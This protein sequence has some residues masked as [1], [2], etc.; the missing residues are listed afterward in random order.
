MALGLFIRAY[1]EAFLLI[2]YQVQ[3][4]PLHRVPLSAIYQASYGLREGGGILIRT[5]DGQKK[6]PF[7]MFSATY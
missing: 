1:E 6:K 7:P 5:H 4:S 2:T 3:Y